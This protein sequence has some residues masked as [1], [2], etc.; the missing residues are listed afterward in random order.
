VD[1]PILSGIYTD[2]SADIRTRYPRNLVPVSKASG[3]SGGYLRPGDGLVEHLTGPGA[4]RGGIL[5]Q[6]VHYRVMGT[7]LVKVYASGGFDVLGDVGPGGFCTFDYSFD[8]LAM[9]S[10]GRLYYLL[11]GTLIQVTDPDLGVAL[12]VLWADGYFFT[13]DGEFIVQTELLDPT[14]IDPLKYGSSEIDPDPILR[15][16]KLNGE[17]YA[18][19]RNTSEVFDN[20]GGTGFVL[21]RIESAMVQRGTVGT[22]AACAFGDGAIAF[23]GSGRNETVGV[24][25]MANGS[26][27]RVSTREIDTLLQGLSDAELADIVLEGRFDR[28]HEWLYVH[29]PTQTLVFDAGA[30]R[31]FRT[32]VWYT[33]D[34]SAAPT[35]TRYR[36]RG[37]VLSDGVWYAGDPTTEKLASIATTTARHYGSDVAHE[38]GTMIVYGDG[39]D[40]IVHELELVA[41]PG[42]VAVGLDPVVWTSYSLDGVT[43]SV[44]KYIPAGKIGERAKRIGWRTQ[45]TIR[46]W[47]IQRFRWRSDTLMSVAKLSMRVEPMR[48]RPGA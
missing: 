41:L 20:V 16:L 21:R 47:R 14:Q 26:S 40:A 1:V 31:E 12:C 43:F 25:M 13:T 2:Q 28:G 33:L 23:V 38:F 32:A 17:V 18:I 29:L 8:R 27:V 19:N 42:R 34:S 48:T 3:I 22:N 10:G 44:E 9:T 4:D 5:W 7:S 39:D 6:G 30:T 24:Y 36:A 46:N 11:G 15:L 45:G 37:F 35:P